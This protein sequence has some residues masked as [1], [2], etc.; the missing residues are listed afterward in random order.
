MFTLRIIILIVPLKYD[1]C[2]CE[3][4]R[5]EYKI[6]KQCC[7]MFLC[8]AYDTSTTCVPCPQLT[9]I[10]EPNGL[11]E[12]FP[13]T[14]CDADRGLR[15]SEVCTRSSDTVCGPLER[16][17]CIEKQK[18]S[19]TLAVQHSECNP[20]QYIKQAGTGS[21][22]TVCADCTADT[23]SNGSFSSCLPHTKCEAMGLAETNLGTHS[24]DSECGNPPTAVAII[25]SSVI[26]TLILITVVSVLIFKHIRKKKLSKSS[27]NSKGKNKVYHRK[28]YTRQLFSLY[29]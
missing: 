29:T 1:L 22:D 25:A 12:C 14:V 16:F 8:A 27:G 6:D 28:K 19:C 7:P 10:D 3:C 18:G 2:Y 15:L 20:G 13:C 9:F 5:A 17:Y 21:T 23:Y 24:S 4:A 11:V 26:V